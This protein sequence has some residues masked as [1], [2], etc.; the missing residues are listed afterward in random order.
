M[1]TRLGY[2]AVLGAACGWALIGVFTRE[3]GDD[4]LPA[5]DLAAWRAL[6]GGVCFALHLV[7]LRR[8]SPRLDTPPDTATWW[9]LAAFTAVG[10][11]V[12][13]ASLPLAIEA[14]G[15]TIAYVLLYTAPAWVAVGA[16]V[17]LG[18]RLDGLD[19]ALVA[20]TLGGATMIVVAGGRAITVNVASVGWGAASGI[21]YASYYLLG[22]RL[23]DRLGAVRTYAI[24]LPAG[25]ATLLLVVRPSWP[26]GS[27]WLLLACL[28]VVSTWLPYLLLALG[29]ARVRSSRAVVVATLEPVLAA[30][31]GA[32][33]YGERLGVVGVV[34]AAVV[35]VAAAFSSTRR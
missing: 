22:R 14:G 19:V 5:A 1:S 27:Q 31:I 3:L 32:A 21:T 16:A 13:F 33:F 18:E 17:F 8:R 15:I 24:C 7:A 25:G 2:L 30:M 35:L 28:A 10:V 23:F 34:G 6:L 20:A 9:R 29:L 4:G 12:F 26:S 11:V